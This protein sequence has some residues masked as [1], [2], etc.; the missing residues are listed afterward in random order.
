MDDKIDS[1]F[2]DIVISFLPRPDTENIVNVEPS[3]ITETSSEQ[4]TA[5]VKIYYLQ[6]DFERNILKS[7]EGIH[8][9]PKFTWTTFYLDKIATDDQLKMAIKYGL[10]HA[11]GMGNYVILDQGLDN[12]TV[13]IGKPPSIMVNRIMPIDYNEFEITP[14]DIEELKSLYGNLGFESESNNKTNLDQSTFYKNKFKSE[15][16]IGSVSAE[17]FDQTMLYFKNNGEMNVAENGK[18][19]GHV[20]MPSWFKKNITWWLD[21]SI[22]EGEFATSIQYLKE[23]GIL[24]F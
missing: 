2:C 23:N 14:I 6:L 1:S 5:V 19:L 18:F 4:H 3:G 13:G 15:L 17:T 8:S 11:F 9:Y 12:G 20:I 21:G 22:T 16:A 10:G 24:T 7:G